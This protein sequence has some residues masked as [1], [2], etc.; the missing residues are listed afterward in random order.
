MSAGRKR[1]NNKKPVPVNEV[2]S[3]LF[4]GSDASVETIEEEEKVE[5]NEPEEPEEP[6]EYFPDDDD[7][8]VEFTDVTVGFN[9]GDKV[10][11]TGDDD[12]WNDGVI[13]I[14]GKYKINYQKGFVLSMADQQVELSYRDGSGATVEILA[15]GILGNPDNPTRKNTIIDYGGNKGGKGRRLTTRYNFKKG[16]LIKVTFNKPDYNAAYAPFENNV[17]PK[18]IKLLKDVCNLSGD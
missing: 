2:D 17:D 13:C 10:K 18:A 11:R 16:E 12:D 1:V 6:K 4:G 8:E 7:D 9:Y 5:K 15:E 3:E 14:R